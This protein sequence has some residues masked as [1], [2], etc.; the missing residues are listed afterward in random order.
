MAMITFLHICSFINLF[1]CAV[2][3]FLSIKLMRRS[4]E[5]N[6]V[7]ER[8]RKLDGL[9]CRM[10]EELRNITDAIMLSDEPGA[11]LF[12]EKL[13]ELHKQFMAVGKDD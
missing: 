13:T 3:I 6:K 1:S 8:L 11:T 4:T 7:T 9:Y 10:A 2:V 12:Y 5:F